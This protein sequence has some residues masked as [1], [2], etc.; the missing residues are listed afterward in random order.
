L[1]LKKEKERQRKLATQ[2]KLS[3]RRRRSGKKAE[4]RSKNTASAMAILKTIPA[5]DLLREFGGDIADLE[6]CDSGT[7]FGI[8]SDFNKR[9][10][11][12]LW[13]QRW[14][15]ELIEHLRNILMEATRSTLIKPSSSELPD[16]RKKMRLTRRP[17]SQSRSR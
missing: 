10:L 1:G 11:L 6:S 7:Y 4:S 16:V 13:I 5:T 3:K 12:K 15:P 8:A 17:K 14:S 2:K 9:G